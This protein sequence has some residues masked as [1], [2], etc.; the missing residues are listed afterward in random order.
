MQTIERTNA[1]TPSDVNTT[2]APTM[3]S[4][5]YESDEKQLS[6]AVLGDYEFYQIVYSNILYY[7]VMYLLLD[8]LQQHFVLPGDVLATRLSTATFCTTW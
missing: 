7:L 6:A 1:P 4:T 2:G 5:G 8:C 3:T